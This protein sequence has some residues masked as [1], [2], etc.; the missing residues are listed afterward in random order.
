[1]ITT[2]TLV[3][4]TIGKKRY[5]TPLIVILL[6]AITILAACH[7]PSGQQPPPTTPAQ[8]QE[9]TATATNTE[10]SDPYVTIYG[11]RLPEDAAPYAMQTY[12]VACD[13]SRNQTA[14]DFAATVYERICVEE[15]RLNDLFQDQLVTFD[16]DFNIIPASAE[17]WEVSD[18]GLVWT[19]HI[20]PG[21]VWSDETPLTAYDWEA[22]YRM[23]ANP[24][25]EWDFIWFYEGVIENWSAVTN[26]ELPPE[27]LGVRAIDDLTLEFTT[28][29]PQPAFLAMM[30][31]SYVLQKRALE[32]HGPTYNSSVETSVSSG[33]FILTM[34]KPLE[35][36][37]MAANPTYRGYRT[38]YLRQ[39]IGEYRD[40]STAFLAFQH[41]EID[42]LNS[43]FLLPEDYKT[44]EETPVLQDNYLRHH[45]EFRTDYLFFDTYNPP[46]DDLNVRRAFAHA[47]DR[48]TI[49]K[50]V[51]GEIKATPAYSMLM[52][53]FP[54]SDSE[55]K[56]RAYQ[57]YDCDLAQNYLAAA[58]Y[59][60]GEGFPELTMLHRNEPETLT[61][62]YRAAA[63]SIEQCLDITIEVVTKD[64]TVFM[65]R[66][67]AR[68]TRIQFGVVSYGMDYLDPSNLLGVWVSSGR[69]AWKNKAYDDLVRQASSM[70]NNPQQRIET[71]QEAERILVDEVGGVFLTH[72]WQGDLV[73]PYLLGS[74]IREEDAQGTS[75]WRWGNDQAISTIYISKDVENYH[76]Y[77][78]K[79]LR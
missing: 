14:F 16:K 65:E 11:E 23:I 54:A 74:G 9:T 55:H 26:G 49:V 35:R 77:R 53:G 29:T 46:F 2:I 34:Y 31:N 13:I 66:L 24:E 7:P 58:G 17:S 27:E 70:N 67:T 51:F 41:H 21:L 25:Y 33:P 50:E 15:G 62:V 4:S 63:E 72:R 73:Q 69:H 56:L 44:V 22:T 10:P 75:G 1:M 39:I 36:I 61:A 43:L 68:P 79:S 28:L 42:Y 40:M 3:R 47:V 57:Q 52:T 8:N 5:G 78:E 59:P 60:G 76:T 20:R 19:F 18:D 30:Q 45:G 32:Q 6:I 37:E 48:E 64:Y 71:F 38:P 12:K